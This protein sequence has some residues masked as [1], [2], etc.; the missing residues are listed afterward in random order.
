MRRMRWAMAT[1]SV[2]AVTACGS[3]NHAPVVYGSDPSRQTRVYHSPDDIRREQQ[4]RRAQTAQAPVYR[5]PEFKARSSAEV[6]PVK[7]APL[8]AVYLDD[9]ERAR[10]QKASVSSTPPAHLHRA[11]GY[12]EVQ[13]G[14]TVYAI[15]RKFN[16]S[17]AAVIDENDLKKPY[18]L[19]VGQALKL[20]DGAVALRTDAP[21]HN[22]AS[23]RV[24]V[25]KDELYTVR[26][27]DT[28]YSISRRSGVPA[29]NIASANNIAAPYTLDIGQ[30]LLIPQAPT[31]AKPLLTAQKAP[32]QKKAAETPQSEDVAEIARTVSYTKPEPASAKSMFDWP[33]HGAVISEFGAGNLG[34]RN[35]G[36]NIAAPV[37]APVRAAAAGQVVY[38]GS[39]LEGFGNLLLVK[40]QDGYVT[41]YAHNDAMLVKK[42]DQVRKGQVIAKVGQTGAVTT[43]QLHFEIR[44][45][46]DAVD[47][48][49]LLGKP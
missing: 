2:L 4:A 3:H 22:R 41:A 7:L 10:A 42:G 31:G 1:V 27:G 18:T 45:Q 30:R 6:E 24:V 5:Q 26:A 36:V 32:A 44:R 29:A 48:V 49:A 20:P 9:E 15:A 33:L 39:E 11:K 28:L 8:S 37:G 43:P 46:S 16:V 35:D 14:D 12:I 47:P 21:S 13:R 17:P 38:R 34:R 19:K 40:H 23:H 25:A